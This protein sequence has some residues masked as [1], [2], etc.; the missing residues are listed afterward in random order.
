MH[1][2]WIMYAAVY[3]LLHAYLLRV[4]HL[5]YPGEKGLVLA[6]AAVCLVMLV[7][8]VL[9]RVLESAAQYEL[10]RG[11]SFFGTPWLVL[12]TWFCILAAAMDAWNLGVHKLGESHPAVAGLLL[13]VRPTLGIILLIVSLAGL[14]SLVEAYRVRLKKITFRTSRVS[15]P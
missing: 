14:W 13:P 6:G 4:I 11:F 5:A 9:S 1:R 8:L 12:L 10:A 2:L 15:E 7:V 3:L